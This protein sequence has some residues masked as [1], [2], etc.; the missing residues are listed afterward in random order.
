VKVDS[1]SGDF[2]KATSPRPQP[3]SSTTPSKRL[4]TTPPCV[5]AVTAGASSMTAP[6]IRVMNP[7]GPI[8]TERTGSRRTVTTPL[9]A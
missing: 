8:S 2:R 9:R 1:A 4:K 3:A 6:V 5:I 7:D